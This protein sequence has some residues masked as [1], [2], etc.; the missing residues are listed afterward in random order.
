MPR[1][2]LLTGTCGS[3]KTTIAALLAEH[4]TWIH[5]NE[6]LIWHNCFGKNRGQFLSDE[7]RVKRRQV[8]EIV[9]G[10]L[11]QGLHLGLDVV[12]DATVHES[13]PEAYEEYQSLCE[14]HAIE[15]SIRVLHPRL[16]V[17]VARDASRTCWSVGEKGVKELREEFN[18]G[19]LG[20]EC[21]VDNSD[22]TAEETVMRLLNPGAANN[23][24]NRSAKRVSYRCL[25][26]S[27][28]PGY[29]KR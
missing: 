25:S 18:K 22:E 1:V 7:H 13:P 29:T 9:L 4:A 8:H 15:W 21:Y 11:L 10:Q 26:A 3:G 20:A 27:R 5:I 2:L 17:A 23:C 14:A 16:E 19:V 12:I 6:D 28:A 24:I